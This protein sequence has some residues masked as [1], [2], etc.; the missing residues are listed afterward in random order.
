VRDIRL[1]RDQKSGKSKGVGYVDPSRLPPPP[2][3]LN[4]TTCSTRRRTQAIAGS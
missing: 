2:P 3:F 4:P 1:I